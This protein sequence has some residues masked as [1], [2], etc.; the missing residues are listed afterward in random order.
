MFCANCGKNIEEDIELC[1]NCS[2]NPKKAEI[3]IKEKPYSKRKKPVLSIIA[4][5]YGLI[6][7]VSSGLSTNSVSDTIGMLYIINGSLF[8]V[9][10]M[11][12]LG[13]NANKNV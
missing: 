2:K 3:S 5:I 8:I 1:P 11:I 6:W 13:I 7:Y 10:G 12:L 4:F 9:G